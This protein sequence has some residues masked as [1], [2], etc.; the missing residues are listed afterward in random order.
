MNKMAFCFCLQVGYLTGEITTKATYPDRNLL[1]LCCCTVWHSVR[2]LCIS[3]LFLQCR[4]SQHC[5]SLVYGS[6]HYHLPCKPPLSL[7]K[8]KTI[9]LMITWFVKEKLCKCPLSLIKTNDPV[10]EDRLVCK[11][12]T[13]L[14]SWFTFCLSSIYIWLSNN[15]V[16]AQ[17]D[18]LHVDYSERF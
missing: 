7:I 5:K 10:D 15:K 11:G 14:T 4:S 13:L 9:Q 16:P 18:M 8:K 6:S 2:H 3:R 1:L 17:I 12:E